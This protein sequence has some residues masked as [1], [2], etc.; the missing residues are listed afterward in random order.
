MMR[1]WLLSLLCALLVVL[2]GCDAGTDDL[3]QWVAEKQRQAVPHVTPVSEPKRYVP[4]SYTEGAQ[5][6]PFSSERLTT[7]LRR[8]NA[9]SSQSAALIERELHR[10]KEPLES[11]PLDTM[12]MVGSLQRGGQRIAL[13]KVDNLLNQVR[14][15][16]YLGQNYGMVTAVAENQVTLRE[17]VQNAEGE[18][19]ERPAALQLQE[20]TK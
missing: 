12:T 7:A 18:W 5:K 13:I 8:D 16:N 9:F 10:R 6:S 20:H 4:L 14:V 15:G 1:G 2:A 19:I 11:F 3:H 17:I